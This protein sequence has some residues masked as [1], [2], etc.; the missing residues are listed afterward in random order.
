MAVDLEIQTQSVYSEE[1]SVKIILVILGTLPLAVIF[2]LDPLYSLIELKGEPLKGALLFPV[3]ATVMAD[4]IRLKKAIHVV[5]FTAIFIA[6]FGYYSYIS[7]GLPMLKPN[8]TLV[9]AYHNRFAGYM[10]TLL[11]IAFIL[12]FIWKKRV[13][14]C[15]LIIAFIFLVLALILST[16]RGG[17]LAF[18]GIA[19]VWSLYISRARGYSFKKVI[20]YLL[21]VF[22]LVGA[23]SY[24]YFPDV[25]KRIENLSTEF[26]TFNERTELWG[27]AFYAFLERPLYGWGYGNRFYHQD[28]PFVKTPYK[29]APERGEHN[30]FLTV[31][32]HQGII[33]FIPFILFILAATSTFWREALKS[34]G[35][36]SYVLIACA[37]VFIG[38]YVLH[39][40][41]ES[42]F[43]L[44]HIA[45]AFGLGMAALGIRENSDN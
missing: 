43:K 37:S 4:K 18:L 21:S 19:F 25:K 41:L 9:H 8:T 15:L 40:Q 13:S 3:I 22:L 44:Q 31:L 42:M 29:K 39:A 36:K 6:I 28:E 14:R 26:Y 34:E 27:A 23:F 11:P 7:Q 1:H 45:F 17:Y 20:A 32:F 38:N 24:L 5:F 33:G 10:N 35:I 12:Y 30:M 16:S 2:S